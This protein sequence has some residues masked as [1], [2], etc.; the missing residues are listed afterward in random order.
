M[1]PTPTARIRR[2]RIVVSLVAGC[3]VASAAPALALGTTPPPAKAPTDVAIAKAADRGG[4]HPGETIVYTITVTN[5]GGTAVPRT[6]IF[7]SDPMLADLAPA[8]A[9][10]ASIGSLTKMAVRGTAVPPTLVTVI[11]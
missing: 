5:V 7:V 3:L 9:R 1:S 2:R 11:V 4:Y 6:A 10:S 8:G